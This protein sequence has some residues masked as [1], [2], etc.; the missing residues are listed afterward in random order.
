MKPVSFP[1]VHVT[2][3][4]CQDSNRTFKTC[5]AID[6][7]KNKTVLIFSVTGAWFPPIST[8]KLLDYEQH[9]D[10]FKKRGVNDIFC[11]ST[12]DIFVLSKWASENNIKNI[13]MLSDGN[14]EMCE[15]M[16]MLRERFDLNIGVRCASFVSLVVDTQIKCTLSEVDQKHNKKT[17]TYAATHP[18]AMLDWIDK[19][20]QHGSR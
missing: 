1:L 15:L 16:G 20:S 18:R 3:N 9:Y 7:L 6:L 8:K 4:S 12:N 5:E 13:K 19:Y 2:T 10:E 17:C 14:A 11:T